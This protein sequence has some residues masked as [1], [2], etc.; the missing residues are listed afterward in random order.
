LALFAIE[1]EAPD[2]PAP[3]AHSTLPRLDVLELHDNEGNDTDLFKTVRSTLQVVDTHLDY[4]F[5]HYYKRATDLPQSLRCIA[6]EYTTTWRPLS[7]QELDTY[8]NIAEALKSFAQILL[9]L[10]TTPSSTSFRYLTL[11][12]H[13]LGEP[14]LSAHAQA[15]RQACERKG[16]EVFWEQTPREGTTSLV[17]HDLWR[18]ARQLRREQ[19]EE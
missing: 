9:D 16:V 1:Q 8:A 7:P 12:R 3:L 14:S 18:K 6:S 5:Q 2:W 19:S 11:P 17:S 15:V 4:S 13:L 10:P